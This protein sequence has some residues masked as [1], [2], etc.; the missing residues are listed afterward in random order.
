MKRLHLHLNVKEQSFAQ[1]RDFYSVLFD[2]EP[3]TVKPH[4]SKWFL[5]DPKVNFVIETHQ[6][7][8]Q[9]GI[10]HAGIQVDD[11]E[12]LNAIRHRLK[13]SDIPAMDIG[14]A[15]CCYSLSEKTWTADPSGLKWENFQTYGEQDDYGCRT[16]EECKADAT[17]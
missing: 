8:E 6:N 3:T 2:A 5:E 16:A 14:K 11:I 9:E 1:T 13:K 4:Y 15:A 7:D 10:H 17:D 12:E